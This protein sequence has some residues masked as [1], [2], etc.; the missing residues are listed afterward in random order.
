MAMRSRSNSPKL[1][2]LAD[3]VDPIDALC[4]HFNVQATSLIANEP[5]PSFV[6]FPVI[7]DAHMPTHALALMSPENVHLLIPLH[8]DLYNANFRVELL[9][10]PP[11]GTAAPIP[12]TTSGSLIQQVTLPVVQAQVPHVASLPL[13]LL[14][15]L[16][17]ETDTNLLAWS[18]L[19]SEVVEEFPN[20]AAMAQI[21]AH[22]DDEDDFQ[23]RLKFT[24]GLWK[25]TL[26]LGLQN[27]S[28]VGLIH[29][30][31]NVIA[32]A[33]RIRQRSGYY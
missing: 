21:M 24:Q 4:H 7:R 28:I 23:S 22:V 16:D 18:M 14:Y 12:H 13:L 1:T 5:I 8:S 9:P 2:Y 17:L 6:N 10:Q 31:W 26:A 32:E 27:T 11:P 19:P 15:A 30:A 25:N 20:A 33:R 29:T 3:N